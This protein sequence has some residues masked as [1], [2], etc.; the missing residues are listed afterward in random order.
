MLKIGKPVLLLGGLLAM[1][2]PAG[3][4][5]P[6]GRII[7]AEQCWLVPRDKLVISDDPQ[8][9][10]GKYVAVPEGQEGQLLIATLLEK[11]LPGRYRGSLRFRQ[12]TLAPIGRCFSVR[13]AVLPDEPN[14]QQ[15]IMAVSNAYGWRFPGYHGEWVEFPFEFE[16]TDF[17]KSVDINVTRNDS[18]HNW[19]NTTPASALAPAGGLDCITLNPTPEP[20]PPVR[21]VRVWPNKICYR[22]G[23]EAT[24]T[25][26]L[27]N[28]TESRQSGKVRCSAYGELSESEE[29]GK[30]VFALAPRERAEV[31]LPWKPGKL[32]YGL[33]VRAEVWRGT[34]KLDENREYCQVH[35]DAQRV[36]VEGNPDMAYRHDTAQFL[37]QIPLSSRTV[38]AM[39]A[40][41]RR[42]YCN[43]SEASSLYSPGAGF[44][45]Y[46]TRGAWMSY[47][48]GYHRGFRDTILAVGRELAKQGILWTPYFD[49]YSWATR[50]EYWLA[51]KPE[52]FLYDPLTGDVLGSYDTYQL[53]KHKQAGTFGL[54]ISDIGTFNGVPNYAREDTVDYAA[55]QVIEAWK[56]FRFPGV[57]WDF[58][59]TVWPGYADWQGKIV[60]RDYAEADQISA[61]MLQRFKDKIN[62]AIPGFYWGYNAGSLEE[63]RNYPLTNEVRDRGGGYI[64]DECIYAAYETS[65]PYRMWPAYLQYN[66]DLQDWHRQRGGYFNPYAP[67][68]LGSPYAVDRIYD[69]ILRACPG[70]YVHQPYYDSSL[71]FG[72]YAQFMTRYSALF[73]H[74]DRS[75]FPE[76]AKWL[77]VESARPM[78]WENVVYQ[79][80]RTAR[81]RQLIVNLINPPVNAGI[82]EPP[83]DEFPPPAKD[84][85][86]TLRE[87]DGWEVSRAWLVMFES[88]DENAAPRPQ[89]KPLNL[90]RQGAAVTVRVPCI[91]HWKL[92]VFEMTQTGGGR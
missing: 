21:V 43:K 57:R 80:Q 83:H 23:E 87:Q 24:V 50:M 20:A 8:A 52:W 91:F 90:E 29:I 17:P 37:Q 72:N 68:R 77:E 35:R 84:V 6:G 13:I 54:D 92:V 1:A 88:E 56:I 30:Q 66:A 61:R 89:H 75:R 86:V 31:A 62:R 3:A 32:Q 70:N 60:A 11:P 46:D 36:A 73:Y 55:Q 74:E 59:V 5:P 15:R 19:S 9:S 78:W 4:Q 65:N 16:I 27:Q 40:W 26:T 58:H 41:M 42:D 22:P 28:T 7:E 69:T 85:A 64:L 44:D 47:G 45:Q 34:E 48:G 81:D 10:G 33:E 53:W 39:A 79:R 14:A 76:A 18:G 82:N 49:G 51:R 63:I 25:V 38:A 71:R 12:E 2:A 67:T